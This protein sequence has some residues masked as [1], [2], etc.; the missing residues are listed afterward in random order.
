MGGW[1][2]VRHG[3]TQ[4][5]LEGRIQGHTDVPLCEFG[6]KKVRAL[7]R[8][9]ATIPFS[10]VYASDLIRTVETARILIEGTDASVQKDPNL[11]EFAYGAWEGLTLDEVQTQDA[12]SFS[13]RLNRRDVDFAAPGGENAIQLLQRVRRFFDETSEMHGQED[14]L[15]V[16]AHGGSIRALAICL[17][18]LSD[19]HFWRFHVDCASL[20][21]IRTYSGG[22]VLERWNHTVPLGI[23]SLKGSQ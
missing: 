22:R 10:A 13:Q 12:E 8:E 4:W 5:N 3:E 23:E 21:V 15:L 17:L 18:G 14:N 2:L 7:A 9:L 20:S 11:R 6:R 1:H 16:V 19:E